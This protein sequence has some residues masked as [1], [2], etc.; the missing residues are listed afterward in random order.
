MG[1]WDGYY[2]GRK[3]GEWTQNP[4]SAATEK[5]IYLGKGSKYYP[6]IKVGEFLIE[7]GTL[8]RGDTI[9]IISSSSGMIK[10]KLD[11]LIVNGIE[12][13]GAKKGDRIT[14]PLL[15]KVVAS[16]K[17]YKVIETEPESPAE[18]PNVMCFW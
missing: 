18:T 15:N 14:L 11:K 5:K 2:L 1:S 6:K 3:L 16:D 10:E 12:S 4:G 9:M 17:L 7:S 13:K 8:H